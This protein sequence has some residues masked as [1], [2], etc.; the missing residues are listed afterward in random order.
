MYNLR[1]TF[2]G[3]ER[4]KFSLGLMLVLVAALPFNLNE[5]F[6]EQVALNILSLVNLGMGSC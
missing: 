2:P 5:L 6:C 4:P 1:T 3:Q